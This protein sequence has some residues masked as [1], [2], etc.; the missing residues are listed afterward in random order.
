MEGKIISFDLTNI[1]LPGW[2]F[3]NTI[4]EEGSKGNANFQGAT[5][6]GTDLKKTIFSNKLSEAIFYNATLENITF[7]GEIVDSNFSKAHLKNVTFREN[8]TE[9]NFEGATLENITFK[10]DVNGNFKGAHLNNVS[11]NGEFSG[12]FGGAQLINCVNKKGQL[13]A[14][15]LGKITLYSNIHQSQEKKENKKESK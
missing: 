9:N 4:F 1:N 8:A 3:I 12:N 6:Q 15:Q 7:N 13:L 14:V 2:T 10:H 11:F 5:L